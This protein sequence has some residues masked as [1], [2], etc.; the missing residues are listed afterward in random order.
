M[1]RSS[2]LLTTVLI[3]GSVLLV[4]AVIGIFI[5]SGKANKLADEKDALLTERQANMEERQQLM[6]ANQTL[7]AQL[8]DLREEMETQK[9]AHAEELRVRN[10]RI[11]RLSRTNTETEMALQEKTIAFQELEVEWEQLKAQYAEVLSN[12]DDTKNELTQLTLQCQMLT[13]S[14]NAARGLKAY[15]ISPL[16]KWDRWI[17]ADR[18]NVYRAKR[19]DETYIDFEINGGFFAPHGNRTVH[20]VMAAPDGSIINPGGGMFS[21]TDASE[22]MPY[23]IMTDINYSGSPVKVDFTVVHSER[24]T[25]GTYGIQVY[26]GGEL[27]R[28]SSIILE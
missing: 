5:Y 26:I 24:L 6:A 23:T 19:V 21:P 2:N 18:Y 15:N 17:C 27:V 9:E 13:D 22:Q 20:L 11:A 25:P 14:I 12:W 3:A 10:N 28:E 8:G 7:E 1:E 4:A 16:T